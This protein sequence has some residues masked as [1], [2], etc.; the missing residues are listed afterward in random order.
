MSQDEKKTGMSDAELEDMSRFAG[1]LFDQLKSKDFSTR[2]AF[3]LGFIRGR[4]FTLEQ[5]GVYDD[6]E[7][8][9]LDEPPELVKQYMRFEDENA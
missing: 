2:D 7:D 1:W 4:E 8:L 5:L 9:I 6:D 3:I